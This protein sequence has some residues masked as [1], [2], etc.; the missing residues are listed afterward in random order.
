MMAGFIGSELT[1]G[2]I[3]FFLALVLAVLGFAW[4][5]RLRR[6]D[7]HCETVLFRPSLF[8]T[9]GLLLLPLKNRRVLL[10]GQPL[11]IKRKKRRKK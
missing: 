2:T 8:F 3:A 1:Y 7:P 5:I 11:K 10:A 6:I 4:A 9:S